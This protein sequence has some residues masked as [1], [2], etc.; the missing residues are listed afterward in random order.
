MCRFHLTVSPEISGQVMR[1][2]YVFCDLIY[3]TQRLCS[4]ATVEQGWKTQNRACELKG[5]LKT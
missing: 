2:M 3:P 5:T 4:V 1:Y